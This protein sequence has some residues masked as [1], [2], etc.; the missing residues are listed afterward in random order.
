MGR[1]Y[2]LYILASPSRELYVGVTNDLVRRLAEHR[3]GMSP[4][5]FTSRHDTKRLVY[6]EATYD[7]SAAI[8][9]EKQIKRWTR[10][11]KLALIELSNPEWGDLGEGW[12][13]RGVSTPSLRSG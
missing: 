10:R 6:Y 11:R 12:A 13:T 9:R 3:A 8:R 7:I 2:F 5:A 4:R 1:T